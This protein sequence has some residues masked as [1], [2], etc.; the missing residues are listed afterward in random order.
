[1]SWK[2]GFIGLLHVVSG[3]VIA[4]FLPLML[5]ILLHPMPCAAYSSAGVAWK[6]WLM[7]ALD[8]LWIGLLV[9]LDIRLVR[10]DGM[11]K[12]GLLCLALLF[13]M[14]TAAGRWSIMH[15]FL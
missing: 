6:G 7:L 14:G 5:S 11:K 9:L 13:W 1:M 12:R 2:V 10:K 4:F 3:F 15:A 8:C